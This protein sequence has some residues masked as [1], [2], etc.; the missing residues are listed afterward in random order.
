MTKLISAGLARLWKAKIF[1]FV[2]IAI[3]AIS[4]FVIVNQYI[5]S[6]SYEIVMSLNSFVLGYALV[7]VVAAPVFS[8]LFLGTEYSDGT[9]RN[10][11]VV[12]HTRASI[13][14]ANLFVTIVSA[15]LMCAAFFLTAFAVGLPL[16]G[17]LNLSDIGVL[18]FLAMILGTIFMVCAICAI[19]T[20][21]SMLVSN[22]AV[23]A[24]VSVLFMIGLLIFGIQ[25][26]SR[27]LEPE[28]YSGYQFGTVTENGEPE[29]EEMMEK[30]PLFL[31]GTK[32]KV[33]E[34]VYDIVPGGQALQYANMK[35]DHL[36]QMMLYSMAIT[37]VASAF[38][39]AVFRKKNIN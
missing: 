8:S 13:Y 26:E 31:T 20:A 33:Y 27:L 11:L 29:F 23:S 37:V 14:A 4:A 34:A 2:M 16:V 24:I 32:R 19:L 15:L 25:I 22:K 28:F 5:T 30:N 9:V 36:W 35:A 1:W 17:P 10:K 39:Y 38:G 21:I 6:L 7:I 3:V 12:G 18:G